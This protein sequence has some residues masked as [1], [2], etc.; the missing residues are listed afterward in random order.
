MPVIY[1]KI[2]DKRSV[3]QVDI[4]HFMDEAIKEAKIGIKKKRGVHLEL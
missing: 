4:V 2:K 1:T 3:L